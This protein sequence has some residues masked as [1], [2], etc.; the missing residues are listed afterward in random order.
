MR[1]TAILAKG[2][3][4]TKINRIPTGRAIA[5]EFNGIRIVNVYAPSGRAQGRNESAPLI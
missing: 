2:E 5:A 4:L 3:L 1:G